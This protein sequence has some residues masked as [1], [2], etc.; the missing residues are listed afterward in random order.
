MACTRTVPRVSEIIRLHFIVPRRHRIHHRLRWIH[1]G[2]RRPVQVFTVRAILFMRHG[3]AISPTLSCIC[4]GG[5]PIER[6]SLMFGTVFIV[7][8]QG[9]IL[10]GFGWRR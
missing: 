9:S 10:N 8:L 5:I 3:A 4:N 1:G 7:F 2:I 6:A